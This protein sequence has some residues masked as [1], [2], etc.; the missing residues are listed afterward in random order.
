MVEIRD[1]PASEVQQLVRN[2]LRTQLITTW[3]IYHSSRQIRSNSTGQQP[4]T[5]QSERVALLEQRLQA[6][7][8]SRGKRERSE[9]RPQ[10]R[11]WDRESVLP[12]QPSVPHWFL[13][14][15]CPNLISASGNQS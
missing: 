8:D 10:A 9:F 2:D 1:T 14:M 4:C 13:Q 15:F 7:R 3:T 6:N 5:Q 12:V 11:V